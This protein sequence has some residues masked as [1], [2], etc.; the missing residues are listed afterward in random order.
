MN[1][2]LSILKSEDYSKS[3]QKITLDDKSSFVGSE[4]CMDNIKMILCGK[5]EYSRKVYYCFKPA[6]GSDEY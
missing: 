5:I 1:S 3:K 2:C 4:E 6:R